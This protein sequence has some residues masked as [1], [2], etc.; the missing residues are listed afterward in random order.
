[1]LKVED[2][3]N[4]YKPYYPSMKTMTFL[5]YIYSPLIWILF[6]MRQGKAMQPIFH[7]L[8]EIFEISISIW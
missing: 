6:K 7:I 4:F 8:I 3:N 1:M 5:L 2:L